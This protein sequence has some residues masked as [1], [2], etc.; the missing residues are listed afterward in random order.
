[1]RW[2]PRR[3]VSSSPL[4]VLGDLAPL[5]TGLPTERR[6]NLAT[7]HPY[8]VAQALARVQQYPRPNGCKRG[9]PCASATHAW[10]AVASKKPS[11]CRRR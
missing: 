7:K 6:Y 1:M 2:K 10:L 9:R 4:Q 11:G 5:P 3:G 8:A